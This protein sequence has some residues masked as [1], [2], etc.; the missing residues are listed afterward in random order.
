MRSEQRSNTLKIFSMG[1]FVLFI[2]SAIFILNTDASAQNKS[3]KQQLKFP[4][5]KID[6]RPDL[7]VYQFRLI[8]D[9][10]STGKFSG[11][12]KIKNI[13]RS[14]AFISSGWPLVKTNH[15]E[16]PMNIWSG[17]I[18]MRDV[19]IPPGGKYLYRTNFYSTQYCT[20]G[21]HTINVKIDPE[22]KIDESNENNNTG[23]AMIVLT[24][25]TGE[26]TRPDLIVDRVYSDP[27]SITLGDDFQIVVV[28]KNI[29]IAEAKIFGGGADL[30]KCA[31]LIPKPNHNIIKIAPGGYKEFRRTPKQYERGTFTWVVEIDH[32]HD[33]KESNE[34]NNT[35]NFIITIN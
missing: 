13:G 28:V 17:G 8:L 35:H 2:F 9:N 14:D 7:I 31:N 12:L 3:S 34:N 30:I 18:L 24:H 19:S 20:P 16:G 22:N 29:G 6:T 10:P 4:Q 25:N 26:I 33:V 11:Y 27:L 23:S 15:V 5:K 32:N 21:T 1:I